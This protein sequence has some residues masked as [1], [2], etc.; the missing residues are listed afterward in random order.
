[1]YVSIYNYIYSYIS[2]YNM[3]PVYLI[4]LYNI[5]LYMYIFINRTYSHGNIAI[6]ISIVMVSVRS[7]VL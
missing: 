6:N 2:Y 4:K 7:H 3:N 5:K 1:M